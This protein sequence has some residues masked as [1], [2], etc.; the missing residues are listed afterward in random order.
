MQQQYVVDVGTITGIVI[1][2]AIITSP[3]CPLSSYDPHQ[4]I[5]HRFHC[6]KPRVVWQLFVC[7]IIRIP[8]GRV[9]MR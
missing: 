8:V 6:R 4:M 5:T 7:Q 2:T 9:S 3:P 1:A